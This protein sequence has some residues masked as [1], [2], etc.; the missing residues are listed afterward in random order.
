MQVLYEEGA[1]KWMQDMAR[2]ILALLDTVYPG[3][4]WSVR[5]YGD[6]TGGGYHIQH[7]EFEGQNFGMNQPRAHLFSSASELRNDVIR[8]GGELLERCNLAR[9]RYQGEEIKKMEGVPDKFQ[10]PEYRRELEQKN[11][12]AVAEVIREYQQA[13]KEDKQNG[14]ENGLPKAQ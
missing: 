12:D 11:R 2:D 3:H 5:V 6:A 9:R 13:T 1:T 8:K 10:P 4:P 7:L 14:A